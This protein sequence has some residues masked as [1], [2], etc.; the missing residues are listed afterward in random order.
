MHTFDRRTD[1]ETDGQTDRQTDR[2]LIARPRL[3]SMQR[4]NKIGYKPKETWVVGLSSNRV[5]LDPRG[6]IHWFSRRGH[7]QRNIVDMWAY[8]YHGAC[9]IYM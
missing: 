6:G 8:Q 5:R 4:G 7:R 3:H 2:I 1:G 9:T